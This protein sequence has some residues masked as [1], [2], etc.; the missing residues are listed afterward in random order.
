ME[1]NISMSG[2]S[3]WQRGPHS[4]TF[5]KVSGAAY[6]RVCVCEQGSKLQIRIRRINNCFMSEVL[7]DNNRAPWHRKTSGVSNVSRSF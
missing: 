6:K 5:T 3:Y 1:T 7:P 4:Q 2:V